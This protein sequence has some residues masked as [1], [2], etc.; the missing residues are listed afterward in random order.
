MVD[1]PIWHPFNN[2]WWTFTTLFFLILFLVRISELTLRLK[3]WSSQT[4]RKI[5]HIIVG[6]L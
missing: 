1:F 6:L 5:V 3:W 4:N 2:D